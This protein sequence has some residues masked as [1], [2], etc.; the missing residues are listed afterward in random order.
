MP[1]R[2][3]QATVRV[4]ALVSVVGCLG[5]VAGWIRLC[6]AGLRRSRWDEVRHE[7]L[8]VPYWV[9]A[10]AGPY[11]LLGLVVFGGGSLL[12]AAVGWPSL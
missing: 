8:I 9:A 2:V 11:A 6:L 4:L 10:H 1:L 5:S 3:A 12:M 7:P